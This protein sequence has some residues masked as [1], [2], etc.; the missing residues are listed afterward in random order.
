M[1]Q[2][3]LICGPA[4]APIVRARP[5]ICGRVNRKRHCGLGFR[6]RSIPRRSRLRPGCRGRGADRRYGATLCPSRGATILWQGV[7][8]TCLSTIETTRKPRKGMK[9]TRVPS[10]DPASWSTFFETQAAASAAVMGL[11]FVAITINLGQIIGSPRLMARAGEALIQLGTVLAAATF[12]LAP[13]GS[14]AIG[15]ELLAVGVVASLVAWRLRRHG[16]PTQR[17]EDDVGEPKGR[18]VASGP[19]WGENDASGARSIE[20]ECDCSLCDRRCQRHRAGRWR[21]V[22]GPCRS[23][24]RVSGG[25]VRCLGVGYRDTSLSLVWRL[26]RELTYLDV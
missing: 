17:G 23:A 7:P 2:L 12:A 22:L 25:D 20:R 1:G 11:V 10:Y 26:F 16:R 24:G 9:E 21:P 18:R 13:Q 19:G 4:P 3:R 8:L 5:A 14:D 6:D 15:A